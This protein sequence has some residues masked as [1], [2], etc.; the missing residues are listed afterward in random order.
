MFVCVC[1]ENN[2]KVKKFFVEVSFR[3]ISEKVSMLLPWILKEIHSLRLFLVF[4]VV[5][6]NVF[7]TS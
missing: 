4:R 1:I 2:A 6:A 5:D 3:F 7:V